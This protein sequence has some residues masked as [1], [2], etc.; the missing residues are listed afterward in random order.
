MHFFFKA[1]CVTLSFV[2]SDASSTAWQKDAS[3]NMKR[4]LNYTI[5]ISNPLI[6]KSSTATENQVCLQISVNGVFAHFEWMNR[7][8]MLACALITTCQTLYKE[9]RDGQYY[10]LDSEVYT[11]D[12]PYHD[13]F[14]TQNRYYI[15]RNSKKKC[16]L[17]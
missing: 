5:A 9:S 13:Y 6:G 14:Y 4:I 2:L 16:R 12:V 7:G 1:S 11:H 10:L 3:G 15:I 8:L 17:R